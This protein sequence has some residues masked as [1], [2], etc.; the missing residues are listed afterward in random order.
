LKFLMCYCCSK[1]HKTTESIIKDSGAGT[2]PAVLFTGNGY[3]VYRPIA[4]LV[5]ENEPLFEPYEKIDMKRRF[6]KFSEGQPYD[7][8]AYTSWSNN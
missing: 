8:T 2:E 6:G 3:Q 1:L 4:L 7:K 5:L